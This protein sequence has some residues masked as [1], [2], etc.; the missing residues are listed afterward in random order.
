[1]KA[2]MNNKDGNWLL[3]LMVVAVCLQFS[4]FNFQF[5]ICSAQPKKS[6]VQ[7]TQQA[8]QQKKGVNGKKQKEKTLILIGQKRIILHQIQM[9]HFIH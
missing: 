7:T 1:M 3:R 9:F 4:I 8:Q 5:S 6:R 2:K